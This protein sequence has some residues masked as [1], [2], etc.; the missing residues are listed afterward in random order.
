MARFLL[1]LAAVPLLWFGG[2]ALVRLLASDETLIRWAIE[3]MEEGYNEGDVG[4]AI[5]PV[6]E[7]WAHEGYEFDRELLRAVLVGEFLQDRDPETKKLLRR[8]RLV[9][10]S[11]V[12]EAEG[13]GARARVEAVF[14]RREQGEWR[15]VWHAHV[16]SDWRRTED[17]WRLTSSR[18]EDRAGTQ[19]SR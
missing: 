6:H 16:E 1:A 19:L 9:E 13:D 14:S 2:R 7:R 18:H 17:G 8:V 3:D 12:V 4:D 15:D 5:G 11:L 10:D